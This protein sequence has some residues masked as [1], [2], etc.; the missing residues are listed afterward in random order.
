[1]VNK[2]Y[3][4]KKQ[5]HLG[6]HKAT[7]KVTGKLVT[8]PWVTEYLEYLFVQSS[9]KIQHLRTKFKKLIEKFENHKHKESFLQDLSQKKINK[10]SK[11]SQDWIVDLNNTEIFELCKILPNNNVLTL[12]P[13]AAEDEI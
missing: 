7:R 9:S 12:N 4:A 10:L 5:D 13:S 3:K 11:E 2:I 6:N 8:T 1:M